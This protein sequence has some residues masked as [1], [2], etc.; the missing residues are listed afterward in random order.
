M[1]V[2]RFS[3]RHIYA[4]ALRHMLDC[5]ERYEL[6]SFGRDYSAEIKDPASGC[7]WYIHYLTSASGREAIMKPI[8]EEAPIPSLCDFC[9]HPECCDICPVYRENNPL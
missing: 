4:K 1:F 3:H 2:L 8:K 6:V 7:G 9:L 5:S